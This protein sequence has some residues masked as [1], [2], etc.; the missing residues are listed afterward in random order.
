MS[1]KDDE[2]N[3]KVITP[4]GPRDRAMVTEVPA[5]SAVQSTA[6]G[7][8]VIVNPALRDLVVTPGGYRHRS[9]VHVIGPGHIL[10]GS[11]GQIRKLDRET[12]AEAT[13]FG[14]ISPRDRL[15]PLMPDNVYVPPGIA[16]GLGVGW[17]TYASWPNNTG[18]HLTLFRTTW[19]VPEPPSTQ[20][21][22][23]VFF[24][25]G[26]QN[27]TMIYQPVLQWGPSADGGGSYWAIASWYADGQN[28]LAFKTP[29]VRVNPGD[30]LVGVMTLTGQSAGGFSYNCE[31]Q[32]IGGTSLPI[33]NVQE[34]T[35]C[36]ETLEAYGL[37][38]A[39]DYPAS[40][41]TAFTSIEIQVGGQQAAI[42]W[43]PSSKVTDIGQH[44]VIVSNASPSG[45]VDLYYNDWSL[46][47]INL[48]GLTAGHAAVG[49]P[50][51][52]VWNKQTHVLYRDAT[53]TIWDSW[54]DG[55]GSQRWNLQQ[56]N[57]GG[58][59]AGRA[60]VGDPA[61]FVWYNQT[62]VLYRDNAGNV[63]D[64][65][66]PGSGGQWSLQQ[67][68]LNGVTSGPAAMGDPVSFNYLNQSHV[69][70]RD[71]AGRIWDSWYGAG[72]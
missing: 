8:R 45:E 6:G 53:G 1:T 68:N 54:F 67:I 70:Y 17:I 3:G 9:M 34:L 59:T 10:D 5:G 51:T 13:N 64:S 63:L 21:G 28:G 33:Q 47:Q 44:T 43:A 16:P 38:V 14:T 40:G 25:S 27:S 42:M 30:V 32:G 58:L 37:K 55:G 50:A 11:G 31:F 2:Q 46:Q 35:W 36:V 56:I 29:L 48:S 24:F 57:M 39:T 72:R 18:L 65:W 20:N 52:F 41:E 4:G 62:H 23:V 22:Q 49:D 71:N 69:L 61:S 26:I 7:E 12:G 60:A 66:Y 19:V 15:K